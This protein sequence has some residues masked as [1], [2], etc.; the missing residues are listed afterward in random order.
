MANRTKAAEERLERLD[1]EMDEAERKMQKAIQD[2]ADKRVPWALAAI[3]LSRAID[4]DKA[5]EEGGMLG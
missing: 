4:E 5:E 2:Y 3:Q 1:K